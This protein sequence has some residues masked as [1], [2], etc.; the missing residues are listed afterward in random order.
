[1]TPLTPT[2][3]WRG[4][5]KELRIPVVRMGSP[6]I[7]EGR[8]M[9]PTASDPETRILPVTTKTSKIHKQILLV[10]I[11]IYCVVTQH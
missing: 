8:G 2:Y 1:M 9:S 6:F 10:V 7:H 3:R 4:V 11:L 5:D